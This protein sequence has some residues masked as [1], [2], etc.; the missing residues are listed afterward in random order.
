MQT[1][2]SPYLEALKQSVKRKISVL[3]DNRTVE[4]VANDA[5]TFHFKDKGSLA[6][7][8]YYRETVD[9]REWFL[10]TPNFFRVFK[11]KYSLQGIDNAYL[12]DLENKK[13][14]ILSLIDHN[15]L[16][17]LYFGY[18]ANAQLQ[19]GNRV[20][21]K[22]LG[23]FFAKLVHT[24]QPED[25]CAL[26]NPIKEHFGLGSESFFIAF[27][28]LSNAYKEWASENPD[29]MQQ[30]RMEIEHNQIGQSFSAKMT[31]LKLLDLIFW[32]QA[33]KVE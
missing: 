13:K 27:I 4:Q 12:D 21:R 8:N 23:S 26:D 20:V 31:D 25:F 10:N 17:D 14:T 16:A 5:F 3:I 24:F 29:L 7:Q 18:F 1:E 22:K 15:E 19:H 9:N 32:F 6:F 2:I 28:I 30:I 11:Q 33:N